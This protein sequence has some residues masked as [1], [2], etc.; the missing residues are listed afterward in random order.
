MA[1]YHDLVTQKSWEELWR[2][3]KF[4]DFVLIG[5][6]AIYFY[7]QTLKSK[8]IDILVNY[9]QLPRLQEQYSF[10]KNDRLKKY[11]AIREDVQIDIYLPSYSKI[12]IPV[13]VLMQHVRSLEGFSVLDAD[14]LFALKLYT[15]TQ[16]G[17]SPKGRKDFLDLLSLLIAKVVVLEKCQ[18]ILKEYSLTEGTALFHEFLSEAVEVPEL[19]LNQHQYAKLKREIQQQFPLSEKTA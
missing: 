19:R 7:A 1:Y 3:K 6:W 9:D 13:E 8:D 15:L 4:I 11:E 10:S 16:R 18:R 14:Y 5:G 2:L 12:G 17:R